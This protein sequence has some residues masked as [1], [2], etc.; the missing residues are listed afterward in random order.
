MVPH[1]HQA[2]AQNASK[3]NGVFV[4]LDYKDFLKLINEKDNLLIVHSE[5][6]IFSNQYIYLTSYK[7]FVFYCKHKEQLPLPGKHE[8]IYS[9]HVSLPMQ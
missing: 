8:K 3:M 6:G 4:K 5:V 2:H 7:G 1:V 9:N